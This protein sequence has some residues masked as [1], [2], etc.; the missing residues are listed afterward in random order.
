MGQRLGLRKGAHVLRPVGEQHPHRVA[1]RLRIAIL[2]MVQPRCHLK[3]LPQRDAPARVARLAPGRNRHR[4][5]DCQP[6]VRDHQADQHR[7]HA[8]GDRPGHQFGIGTKAGGIAFRDNIPVAHD[9]QRAGLP[10][11][12]I[13]EQRV[14]RTAQGRF[15]HHRVAGDGINRRGIGGIACP[16]RRPGDRYGHAQRHAKALYAFAIHLHTARP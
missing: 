7:R 13:L 2:D 11:V 10:H 1:R 6:P 4:R 14:D 5:V 12:A 15:V 9:Q 3:Q 16:R 8:L